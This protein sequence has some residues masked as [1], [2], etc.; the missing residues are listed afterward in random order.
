MRNSEAQDHER[1]ILQRVELWISEGEDDGEDRAGYV[2]Q[3]DG[4]E[5]RDGPVAARADYDVEIAT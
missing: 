2:A 5:G 1:I 3:Q 4:P